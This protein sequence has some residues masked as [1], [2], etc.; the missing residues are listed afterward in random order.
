M[1]NLMDRVVDIVAR[2][3]DEIL[4]VYRTDFDVTAK[5]DSSP[6][7]QADL[8][9]H[10]VIVAALAELTPDVPIV[11]E[12]SV[13]PPFDIRGKWPRYWLVDP[14][15]GTREFIAR[16]GEF[17]VNV[18]LIEGHQPVLGVVG[19][20]AQ[21]VIFT[22]DVQSSRAERRAGGGRTSLRSRRMRGTT[23]V[24]VVA[25]RSHGGERLEQFIEQLRTR[26]ANV[27]RAPVGSSL[28]LCILAEG[29]AD[30]YPRLGPTSEWD[31]AAAHAVLEAAGGR[32]ATFD[33]EVLRYNAKES[34]LNPEFFAVGDP[35]F[36]WLEVMPP[37]GS[38]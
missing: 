31:I 38:P 15:D 20:P 1:T 28:K 19:I 5:G 17:T 3:G 2:A 30:L 32:V 35:D 21:D 23:S 33:G 7:T 18:A 26:F 16:N 22:G 13:P 4:R 29:R 10:R 24:A 8:N 36:P 37:P 11:S 34:F 25:S 12:E 6:L 14:L 27:E 9:A